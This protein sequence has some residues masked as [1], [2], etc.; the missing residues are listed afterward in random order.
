MRIALAQLGCALG[1]V[2]SNMARARQVI[3]DAGRRGADLVVFPELFLTG[4][5][6]EPG[7]DLAV[8]PDDHRLAG[9]AGQ[10]RVIGVVI[11]AH[12]G[13]GQGLPYNSAYYLQDR[14]VRHT[15]RKASL[16]SYH[17]FGE[18]R[19]FTAGC[20]LRAF[21]TAWGRMGILICN[22]AWQPGLAA[23]LAHDG[24][25]IMVIPASSADSSLSESLNI[26]RT[27]RSITSMYGAVFQC[28][29]I[30]VNRVGAEGGL[31]FT[32]GSH[33]IDPRGDLV[34]EAAPYREDVLLVDLDL[35]SAAR[36]RQA[37]PLLRNPR[38]ELVHRELGRLLGSSAGPGLAS[39]QPASG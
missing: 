6:T 26:R 30:F 33:V 13:S 24:A 31:I 25:H 10:E 39:T 37:V 21:D 15:Q 23:V 16:V 2:A 35:G 5:A 19:Q 18:D 11:G 12:E 7:Q 36:H 38:L 9:L 22:D 29:V 28:H 3:A 20:G 1:D 34:A 4:Y 8:G 32:G 17:I 27:W 14:G